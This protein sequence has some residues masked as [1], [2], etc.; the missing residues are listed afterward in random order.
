MSLIS[1]HVVKCINSLFFT[2][3]SLVLIEKCF[4][5]WI[6]HSLFNYFQVLGYLGCF[7][8]LYYFGKAI[9]TQYLLGN[10]VVPTALET[11]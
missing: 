9:L 1:I 6:Y 5:I 8:Y 4:V 3:I 10:R 7:H 11:V 2:V